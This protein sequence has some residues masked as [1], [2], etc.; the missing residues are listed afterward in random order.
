MGLPIAIG[1][2]N[3]SSYPTKR[4]F[5]E[6]VWLKDEDL[7]LVKTSREPIAHFVTIATHPEWQAV[8][9]FT[10]WDKLRMSATSRAYYNHTVVEL[11]VRIFP[12]SGSVS[13]TFYRDTVYHVKIPSHHHHH[14]PQGNPSN[15]AETA[16]HETPSSETT[17]VGAIPELHCRPQAI[18]SADHRFLSCIVPSLQSVEENQ[19]VVFQLRKPRIDTTVPQKLPP[20]PSYMIA[21]NNSS[22]APGV[23]STTSVAQNHSPTVII[24][25]KPIIIRN[26][27]M[28]SNPTLLGAVCL[29]DLAHRT[30][31]DP[32]HTDV[33]GIR[34]LIIACVNGTI[35]VFSYQQLTLVGI[36]FQL[37]NLSTL[38]MCH[39]GYIARQYPSETLVGRLS[40][41]DHEGKLL[42]FRTQSRRL[43]ENEIHDT[44]TKSEYDNCNGSDDA[45]NLPSFP[46]RSQTTSTGNN[47]TNNHNKLSGGKVALSLVDEAHDIPGTFHTATWISESYLATLD[48]SGTCVTVFALTGESDMTWCALSTISWNATRLEEMA[49]S[50]LH[51]DAVDVIPTTRVAKHQAKDVKNLQ[52]DEHSDCLVISTGLSDTVVF[53]ALW[54]WRTNTE[55]FTLVKRCLSGVL[56]SQLTMVVG[57]NLHPTILSDITFLENDVRLR[58]DTYETALLSPSNCQVVT[59][60]NLRRECPLMLSSKTLSCPRV[61]RCSLRKDYQVEWFEASI[62][63]HYYGAYGPPNIATIGRRWGRSVAIASAK[64]FCTL[65]LLESLYVKETNNAKV[66]QHKC[67]RWFQFKWDSDERKFEVV[68]MTWWEVTERPDS[69]DGKELDDILVVVLHND[70]D[71]SYYLSCWSKKML[72]VH[73][74]LIRSH[75]QPIKSLWGFRLSS[76]FRPTGI[77]LMEQ[78]LSKDLSSSRKAAVL[79]RG[80]R[81]ATTFLYFQLQIVQRSQG[82]KVESYLGSVPLEVRACCALQCSVGGPCDLFLANAKFDFDLAD[83]NV[84]NVETD[85]ANT[86]LAVLGVIRRVGWGLDALA[87]D[88]TGIYL[89]GQVI[90][91]PT[92]AKV[93]GNSFVSSFWFVESRTDMISSIP[94]ECVIWS[95]QLTT[96]KLLTWSIPCDTSSNAVDAYSKMNIDGVGCTMFGNT[97]VHTSSSLFGCASH[98]GSSSRWMQPSS[99]NTSAELPLG[100]LRSSSF[101]CIVGVGQGCQKFH[102]SLGENVSIGNF[103]SDFLQHEIFGPSAFALCPPVFLS[104]M[105]SLTAEL[106]GFNHNIEQAAQV[107]NRYL[108]GKL[109]NLVLGDTSVMALQLFVIRLVEDIAELAKDPHSNDHLTKIRC[110][111]ALVVDAIRKNMRPIQ[112]T[113]FFLEVGRQVEPGC[114]PYIY[115]LPCSPDYTYPGESLDDLITIALTQGSISTTMAALPLISCTKSSHTLCN[116]IFCFCLGKLRDSLRDTNLR[117]NNLSEE[118]KVV[119]DLFCYGLKLEET[120]SFA[121]I[122][123]CS[124]DDATSTSSNDRFYTR[125][126]SQLIFCGLSKWFGKEKDL[127]EEEAEIYE[128]A[129]SFIASSLGSDS[130]ILGSDFSSNSQSGSQ[131]PTLGKAEGWAGT[132]RAT[133]ARFLLETIYSSTMSHPWASAAAYSSVLLGDDRS[134]FQSASCSMIR[135]SIV[136]NYASLMTKLMHNEEG[137]PSFLKA[138]M[139]SCQEQISKEQASEVVDLSLILLESE[140]TGSITV[141]LILTCVIAA[142]VAGRVEEVLVDDSECPILPFYL[143]A[144]QYCRFPLN[145]PLESSLEQRQNESAQCQWL[146]NSVG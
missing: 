48:L 54:H 18:F 107:M 115:P 9:T 132:M 83:G 88:A 74:Q 57:G 31:H 87:L 65:D 134:G 29:C 89:V 111:Y 8:I 108:S 39:M 55:G 125:S 68:A 78:P 86:H 17:A 126:K 119:A 138:N 7:T 43:N 15:V 146:L 52:Y 90:K 79:I 42:L 130:V 12:A 35:Q 135:R 5:I 25:T 112:F 84:P 53:A 101:P 58:K 117:L 80:D 98:A 20:L 49:S 38:P 123:V 50:T 76:G 26:H 51:L 105:F 137:A 99:S 118:R 129:S 66:W 92:P 140:S 116:E 62:P 69:L 103:R 75:D 1:T 85:K 16:S 13:A 109:S 44:K 19:V 2:K 10:Y 63:S 56:Y 27:V 97:H 91:L 106:A 21:P 45:L 28:E 77:D 114:Y 37:P 95:I 133:A 72:D 34:L 82:K 93:S 40:L 141:D 46:K 131:R 120:S 127:D 30:V 96:G 136:E 3:V 144:K 32:I 139:H 122:S 110:I 24:V 100:P 81:E 113:S 64:G 11:Q 6:R 23:G 73:H 104:S 36:L 41:I 14:H 102:R 121:T 67:P 22:A 145:T 124:S 94:M 59:A 128:A 33:A 61:T 70:T 143:E 71:D 4:E 47:K 60:P 142:H